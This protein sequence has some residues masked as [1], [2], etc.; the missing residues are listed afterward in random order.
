MDFCF[1]VIRYPYTYWIII[2]ILMYFQ[3]KQYGENRWDRYNL[4]ICITLIPTFYSFLKHPE[5]LLSVK[6]LCSILIVQ[7]GMRNSPCFQRDLS[8]LK[9]NIY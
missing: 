6:A 3:I 7:G 9:I 5:S 8:Y 4:L 1:I 2:Y